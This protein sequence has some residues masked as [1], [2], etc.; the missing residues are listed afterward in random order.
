L[1][2]RLSGRNPARRGDAA[3]AA[4]ARRRS[5][6]FWEDRLRIS[7]SAGIAD[8]TVDASG[9]SRITNASTANVRSGTGGAA[10]AYHASLTLNKSIDTRRTPAGRR[11]R[12][13]AM[14]ELCLGEAHLAASAN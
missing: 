7:P 1:R 9:I 4:P 6:Y 13:A 8:S 3:R 2:S 10:I 14:A 5:D 12:L 11:G